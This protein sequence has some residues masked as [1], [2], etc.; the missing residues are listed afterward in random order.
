MQQIEVE[1]NELSI[2]IYIDGIPDIGSIPSYELDLLI[3]D[4][5]EEIS[6]YIRQEQESPNEDHPP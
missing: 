3:S 2:P 5:A 4:L 1:N 6:R